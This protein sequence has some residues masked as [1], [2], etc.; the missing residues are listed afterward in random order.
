VVAATSGRH[1]VTE[2]I[3]SPS[4]VSPDRILLA[5]DD[6]TMR[7]LLARWLHEAGYDV[8]ACS[9]GFDLLTHLERSVLSEELPE[10]D[11]VLSDIPPGSALDVL[12][13]FVGCD[14]VPPT[15]FITSLGDRQT[16]ALA[17]HLGAATVIEKPFEK[18]H[19]MAEIRRLLGLTQDST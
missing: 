10:F 9:S 18:G 4:L 5:E 11:V 15:L 12:D 7:A 14:G 16:Q 17:N 6:D 8:T 1:V 13:E 3:E 19:L 2:A